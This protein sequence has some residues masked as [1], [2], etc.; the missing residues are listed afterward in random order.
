MIQAK[1][2]ARY[3]SLPSQAPKMHG[4]TRPLVTIGDLSDFPRC[5]NPNRE[6]RGPSIQV[7]DVVGSVLLPRAHPLTS[8]DR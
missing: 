4:L 8:E 3:K 1:D 7:E 2:T 5:G 6:V